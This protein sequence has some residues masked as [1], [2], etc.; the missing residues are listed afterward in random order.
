M[1]FLIGFFI[2]LLFTVIV[3]K[4]VAKVLE[5]LGLFTT[6]QEGEAK[7][8]LLFG[9][10]F[11]V[12]DD[13]GLHFLTTKI[14]PKALLVPYFGKVYSVD[15]RLDQNYLRSQPV[16]SE[17][18]TPMGVGVWYEMKVNRPVDY[19]FKNNDPRGSLGANVSSST[20]RC[21]SN[22]PLGELLENRHEMSHRVRDEVSPKSTDWGYELG[23]IYI[24]KVHFRDETM[25]RQI[26]N[27]VGNRLLQVTSAIRQ[28]GAN[29]VDVI[30]SAADKK[31]ATEF[32]RAAAMR[33]QIV[34]AAMRQI[35]SNPKILKA[36]IEILE[37]ERITK[38]KGTLTLV[39]AGTGGSVLNALQSGQGEVEIQPSR[40][41]SEPPPPPETA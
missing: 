4:V 39:P 25:I 2:G 3:V 14:G 41:V 5:T 26:E 17:E 37:V 23:S 32:A 21:L 20:V 31:A 22:M 18:G 33:P 28:A 38:S 9:K 13:P 8:F 1:N 15:C 19:L 12:L 11:A 34:G 27:K 24:R 40:Q 7:V 36:L 35:A 16:N 6:I 29:Q 10:V 30:K